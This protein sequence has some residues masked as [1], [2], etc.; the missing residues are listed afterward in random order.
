MADY[1][2]S[3]QELIDAFGRLPGIGPKSAQRITF[4]LLKV[5]K[6]ESQRLVS[7]IS[8]AVEKVSFCTRCYNLAEG[9]LCA[10]CS[11]DQ[12]DAHQLCVVEEPRDVVAIERTRDF[13]ESMGIRTRLSG[14]G[15]GAEVIEKVIAQLEAQQAQLQAKIGAVTGDYQALQQLTATLGLEWRPGRHVP[16]IAGVPQRLLEVFSK[17]AAQ[18]N[19]VMTAKV[20]E[21]YA[22]EGRDPSPFERAAVL[23]MDGVGEWATTSLAVGEGASLEVHKEIH[24]PHSLGLL[25]SALTYYTGFKV[26]SG[27]YKVMG[28]A[29]YGEPRF[30]RL[31]LDNLIDLK[32]DGSFRLNLD[33][34]DYCTGLR[35][36]ND[37]FGAL[38][39][40]KARTPEQQLTQ[41]HMDLAA[42]VQA[43]TEE[44]LTGLQ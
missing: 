44:F 22:R 16:E 21:F 25:Y 28:L 29:P 14:Y 7:A 42:S 15:L 37:K 17:R 30:A 10:I 5:D 13:F 3:I 6:A 18:I 23:T 2:H 19:T 26:N 43:V 24:F 36:T 40:G 27:E 4:H 38:F 9:D 34:F 41:H 32:E 35:M 12:R 39:G 31:I 11:D 1:A 20:A 33:Y 8:S